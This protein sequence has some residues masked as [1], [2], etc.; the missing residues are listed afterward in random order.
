MA[1]AAI[2]GGLLAAVFWGVAPVFSKRGLDSGGNPMLIALVAIATGAVLFWGTLLVTEGTAALDPGLA[3]SGYLVFAVSGLVGTVLGRI[4]SYS[5]VHR[6][7]ASVN[8][9]V[10]ASNPLIA[11]VLAFVF[12]GELVTGTQLIGIVVVVVGLWS[13]TVSKGGDLGGWETR[14]LLFSLLAAAAF[15]VGGVI[16]RYGLTATPAAPLEG[17][18]MNDT[19][20]LIGITAYFLATGGRYVEPISRRTLAYFLTSGV[21]LALGLLSLFW[22]LA[23]GTVAV[24]I[25][26]SGTS[27]LV[28]TVGSA[29][30]LR[31]LERVTRGVTVGAVLVVVGVALISLS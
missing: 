6:V 21:L 8:T 9:A 20:A 7:G 3:P 18:A 14:D 24:V 28:A 23:N 31:D 4:A 25:T 26:L 13:L 10:I 2:L 22:G 16:R 29:V 30:F 11:T 1:T 12:L 15:G 5:G 17:V 19:A 27:P